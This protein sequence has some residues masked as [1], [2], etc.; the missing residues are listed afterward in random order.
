ML[1]GSDL[2]SSLVFAVAAVVR[3]TSQELSGYW[4]GNLR[5]QIIIII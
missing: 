5:N 3:E 1:A 4:K 2:V